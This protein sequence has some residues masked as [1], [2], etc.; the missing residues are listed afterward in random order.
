MHS[1]CVSDGYTDMKNNSEKFTNNS[2]PLYPSLVPYR[3]THILV[4]LVNY[5]QVRVFSNLN[6]LPAFTASQPVFLNTSFVFLPTFCLVHILVAE[7]CEPTF[8]LSW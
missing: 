7:M 3:H 4:Y 5:I 2:F 6:I 1:K 8:H